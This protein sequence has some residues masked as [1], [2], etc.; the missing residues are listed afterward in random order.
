MAK[1]IQLTQGKVA[2]IDDDDFEKISK[3]KWHYEHG[4][5]MGTIDK[6][7]RAYMH[8]F[9]TD[10]PIGKVVDH[11]NGDT[12]DN[13]KSNL[14]ICSQRQNAV[15]INKNRG[16]SKFK[17]VTLRVDKKKWQASITVNYKSIYLGSFDTEIEAAQAYNN[18]ALE[19]FGKYASLNTIDGA[20]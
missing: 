17:G 9:I 5:A 10:C 4:Y 14:R 7:K 3:F 15:N 16:T 12:L 18:A 1:E 6:R 2:I 13:R 19:F 11:V 20:I 8:R